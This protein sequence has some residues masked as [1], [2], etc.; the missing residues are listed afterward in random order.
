M[1]LIVSSPV[2]VNILE[3]LREGILVGDGAMGTLLHECGLLL[4]RSSEEV[5]LTHPELIRKI[6]KD[7][8][9]AGAQV[10]ETNSFGVNRVKLSRRG[11]EDRGMEI[12]RRAAEIAAEAAKGRQVWIAGSVGPL[13]IRLEEAQAQKLPVNDIFQEHISGLISGGVDF[14][15]L[16]TFTDVEE[17]RLALKAARAISNIPVLCSLSF[18]EDGLTHGGV[19]A[20]QAFQALQQAGA[21]MLGANCSVGPRHLCSVFAHHAPKFKGV[22][23][24]AYPNAGRPQFIDGRYSYSTTPSYFAEWGIELVRLGVRLIGGCCGTRPEHIKAL[25]DTLKAADLSKPSTVVVSFES[26]PASKAETPESK[27]LP[28]LLDIIQ[29]RTLIVTEFDSP[30]TLV[31]DTMLKAARALKESGTDFI[32]VADNS[33]AILRMNCVVASHLVER[34][35]GLRAI[36]HLA[37][38]DRNL[39]G[40]QSELMGM[41]ALGLDHVLALTGDPSKVGDSPGATSVYDLNSIS[42]LE[43]V[44]NMNQG[45]TFSGRDL[46]RPARFVAGCSFNPNVKNLDV[47]IKRLERKVAAGAQFVM[48]QPIFNRHLAKATHDA[49]RVFGLPV[50]VG[51]MPLLNARNTEFLHNEVPGIVIPNEVRERMRGKESNEGIREGVQIAKEMAADI[52]KHFK[53]IYLISPLTKYETTATLARAIRDG[54]L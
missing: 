17:I 12:N 2:K 38:R 46:K 13:G 4:D 28:T 29:Q 51:V 34:E 23:Y 1:N 8:L 11:L 36:V 9:D 22:P 20:G 21:D 24:A 5:V 10:L 43:G 25:C 48:T 18:T 41:D 49:T 14:I 30:K 40:T 52:L 33:L 44:R 37:C 3:R 35:T 7:Y 19:A 26:V 47:Q 39:I 45:R 50:L 31:L 54:K 6:H 53:G 32:T 42:L 16:E 27:R 15:F